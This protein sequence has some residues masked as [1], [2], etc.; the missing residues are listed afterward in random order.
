MFRF[1]TVT[2]NLSVGN[3]QFT[4]VG[5]ALLMTSKIMVKK[6]EQAMRVSLL[7]FKHEG[8]CERI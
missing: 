8:I 6:S 2:W 3:L 5:T 1:D 4:Y 7:V